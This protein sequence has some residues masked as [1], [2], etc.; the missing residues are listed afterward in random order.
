[1]IKIALVQ[2][3]RDGNKPPQEYSTWK[4]WWEQK[5]G[6]NFYICSNRLCNRDAEVGAVVRKLADGNGK[7]YVAPLCQP[8]YE[9][10]H[11]FHIQDPNMV[12]L[13]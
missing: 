9:I 12:A 5:K 4:D 1:M 8:C 10:T 2:I 3:I 13:E 11:S 6:R 7:L